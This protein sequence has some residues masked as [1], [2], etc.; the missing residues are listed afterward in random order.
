MKPFSNTWQAYLL[1]LFTA[2]LLFWVYA[3]IS[4]HYF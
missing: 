3:K 2:I 1:W 4:W